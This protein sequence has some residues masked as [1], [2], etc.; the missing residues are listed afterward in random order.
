M[1]ENINESIVREKI[2]RI[3]SSQEFS[4]G[5][6][7]SGLTDYLANWIKS[8]VEWIKDRINSIRMPNMN[9]NVLPEAGLSEG[10]A[11]TLKILA[12]VIIAGLIFIIVFLL[13]RRLRNSKQVRQDEDAMLIYTLRDP[14]LVLETALSFAQKGDYRQGLRY[15]YFS[16]ILKLNELNV[17]RIDKSKTNRQY[18]NEAKSSGYGQYEDVA[19]ITRAFNDYW[20]GNKH[21]DNEIF[22][23][24][25]AKYTGLWKEAGE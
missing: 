25:Y 10:A 23:F 9:I 6:Q 21:I 16:L 8:V 11:L 20:Y 4:K 24:W 22:G 15:L 12:A 5:G 1:L 13:I 18:L 7:G 3:L 19:G 14:E 2:D 17:V